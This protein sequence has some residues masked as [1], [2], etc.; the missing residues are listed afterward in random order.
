MYLRYDEEE[1]LPPPEAEPA[2]RQWLILLLVPHLAPL[3]SLSHREPHG[4]AAL[5]RVLLFA[6]WTRPEVDLLIRGESLDTLPG[7]AG[8]A[9]PST[10]FRQLRQYG[11]WIDS[12]TAARLR[13]GLERV[14]WH[15]LQPGEPERHA[16]GNWMQG[17][18]ER[19]GQ[20]LAGAFQDAVD[21]LQGASGDGQ[22][23]FV[24][25]E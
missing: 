6:G 4:Y 16:L 23:L 14:R 15:F 25:F 13:L 7:K 9:M 20:V 24:V 22:A 10:L 21:M 5:D 11:G 2:W 1:W 3:T 19:A 12:G 18:P 8:V 17:E